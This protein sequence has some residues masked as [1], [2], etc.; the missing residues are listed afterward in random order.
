MHIIEATIFLMKKSLTT[1][2][3]NLSQHKYIKAQVRITGRKGVMPLPYWW[4]CQNK[5]DN[6]HIK[7]S[8]PRAQNSSK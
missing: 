5:G 8:N 1:Y 4:H 7:E 3:K 6:L 2:L